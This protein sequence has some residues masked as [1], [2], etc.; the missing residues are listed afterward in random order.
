M[1]VPA[2]PPFSALPLDR[3][4]PAG[5]AW[6]LYAGDEDALG[7][8]NMLTPEV[9]AAAAASQI[10]SGVR[11]SLDWPLNKPYFPSFGRKAFQHTIE[12]RLRT[13]AE[14][15][16]QR[17]VNDDA[18]IFNTQCSSQWDGFRHYGKLSQKR[19]VDVGIHHT[20]QG[21]THGTGYQKAKV[22]YNNKTQEEVESSDV[23]GIDGTFCRCDQV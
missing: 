17:V 5:N 20:N 15:E 13:T 7:A 10:R 6:G 12:S 18:L 16:D 19:V 1:P 4:G 2:R 14:T 9:V 23:L 22:F 21:L 3:K 11:V 8:L